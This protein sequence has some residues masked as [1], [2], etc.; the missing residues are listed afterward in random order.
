MDTDTKRIETIKIKCKMSD[1]KGI[2]IP[3]GVREILTIE[4]VDQ[5]ATFWFKDSRIT[6]KFATFEIEAD[7]KKGIEPNTAYIERAGKAIT[8]YESKTKEEIKEIVINQLNKMGANA[9]I[10]K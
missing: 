1:P 2:F 4:I 7:K 6:K 10:I 3:R 9:K 8:K 5:V